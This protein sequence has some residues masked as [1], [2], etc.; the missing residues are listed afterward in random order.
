MEVAI[1]GDIPESRALELAAQYIGSLPPRPRHDPSLVPLRQVAGFTGP[2][3]RALD[4]ET[5][6]PRAHP[7][8]LWRC[9]DWQD[10]RGR[11]LMQIAS[12]ILERRVL[13]E[14]REERGLTYSTT[15]YA[16]SSK[17]YPDTS[18]LHVEFTADPDKV[19][20]AAALAKAVVERF[21][22]EGPSDA[23]MDTVRKQLQNIL[24][25][26][27][28]EPRFWIDVLSDLEY[29]GMKLQDLEGAIDKFLAFSKDEVA[30]EMRKT[31]VPER[32]AMVLA[33]PKAPSAAEERRSTN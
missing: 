12:L 19:A 30:A 22:A 2:L 6:T 11:R 10:V 21:V 26:T 20:E 24:G 28:K 31:V 3:E 16:Q 5:I 32:F 4:V 9:A 15:V 7:I 27:Y 25:T 18:A 23:E 1:V 29:H 14:V 17:V 33:R 13:R 8:L